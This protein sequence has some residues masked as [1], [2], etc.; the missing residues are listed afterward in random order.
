MVS[1]QHRDA[2]VR[3]AVST[4]REGAD[5]CGAHES[6]GMKVLLRLRGRRRIGWRRRTRSAPSGIAAGGGEEE[7]ERE[8]ERSEAE[9][10]WEERR[11]EG[12]KGG[13]QDERLGGGRKDGGDAATGRPGRAGMEPGSGEVGRVVTVGAVAFF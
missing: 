11:R 6:G 3:P 10:G 2:D 1:L 7:A 13:R 8:S 4:N 12:E 5:G 9:R